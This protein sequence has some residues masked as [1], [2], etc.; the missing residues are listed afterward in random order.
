[1]KTLV[2]PHKGINS[3]AISNDN[4][5]LAIST[6]HSE[7]RVF[8]IQTSEQIFYLKPNSISTQQFTISS[9][10]KFL[11][12]G[13]VNRTIHMWDLETGLELFEPKGRHFQR[14]ITAV[15]ISETALVVSGN[16]DHS[17]KK[18]DIE[19]WAIIGSFNGH[20][21]EVVCIE[22]SP[23]NQFVVSGSI[24]KSVRVWNFETE[25]EVQRIQGSGSV[26]NC[27]AI[28]SDN[29]VVVSGSADDT[30]KVWK[31][32]RSEELEEPFYMGW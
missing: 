19:T 31:I 5:L 9:N 10:N 8:V 28:S 16:L 2:I 12:A 3:F 24:D 13:G 1:M 7:I 4:S 30:V 20:T 17:M 26:I 25:I 23:N 18:I 32:E 21:D 14:D 22:L 27:I 29:K 6:I 11:V 15:A